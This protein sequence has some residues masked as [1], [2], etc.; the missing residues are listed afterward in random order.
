MSRRPARAERVA[1][2]LHTALA[3]SGTPMLDG[4]A[5]RVLAFE[6]QG[7]GWEG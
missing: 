5:G 3:A 6:P 1:G 2:L 7:L 4:L